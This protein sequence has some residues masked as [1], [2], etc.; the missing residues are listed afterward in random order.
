MDIE[1]NLVTMLVAELCERH[2]G[3]SETKFCRSYKM[4]DDNGGCPLYVDEDNKNQIRT[5]EELKK[6]VN[7]QDL[8]IKLT[9]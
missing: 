6:F 3:N 5:L 4:C 7:E 9:L 1:L 2:I 8:N